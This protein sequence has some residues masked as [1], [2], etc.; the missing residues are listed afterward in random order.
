[1]RKLI[2][3]DRLR[4]GRYHLSCL[5]LAFRVAMRELKEPNAIELSLTKTDLCNTSTTGRMLLLA[6]C[7]GSVLLTLMNFAASWLN[8]NGNSSMVLI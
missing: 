7:Q 3:L 4:Q 6:P 1:M 8:K 5:E 2:G